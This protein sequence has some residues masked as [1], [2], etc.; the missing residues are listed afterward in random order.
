M[1]TNKLI[2][3]CFSIIAIGCVTTNSVDVVTTQGRQLMVNGV[4]YFM[5]GVC[6][7]PVSKNAT[8]RSFENI[9]QDLALMKE[10]GINT[11]RVYEPID[12][13]E[14]LDKIENAGMKVIIG[15]GY[16]QNGYYDILSGSFV[17]YILKYKNHNAILL[18][19]LGNEYNYHPEWFEGDIKNWYQAMNNAAQKIHQIDSNHPVATAHG[20]MP[21]SIAFSMSP[22]IDIWGINV[23]RWIHPSSL[24]YEW[25]EASDKPMYFSETGADSYMSVAKEGFDQGENQK[26]QA[27]ANGKII[28]D[29]LEHTD[30]V[31]GILIFSFTD[32]WWKAGNPNQQDVGGQAPNSSGVPFDRNPNE[33]YWGIVDIERNKKE[34]FYVIK[35]KFN[36]FSLN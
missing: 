32:G 34:T 6:Y 26:A 3:F 7:H 11:L 12:Q 4:S 22:A 29:T 21:D 17:D 1:I 18:W 10:A 25:K 16:N 13:I 5:E 36:Q 31:S 28:D 24:I 27:V 20:D 8:K 9:D 19:E 14:I 23:Y 2:L 35:Q 33:E 30:I 15:F